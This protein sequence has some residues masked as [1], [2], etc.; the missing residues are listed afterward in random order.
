[1][2][3]DSPLQRLYI[4]TLAGFGLT[5][6][7]MLMMMGFSFITRFNTAIAYVL[8]AVFI[9]VTLMGLVW[10]G[11][12]LSLDIKKRAVK[13]QILS[14]NVKLIE[15][16]TAS[17]A[18]NTTENDNNWV[19]EQG[20][21]LILSSGK[22]FKWTE[23]SELIYGYSNGN[24]IRTLKD[25]M[26]DAGYDISQRPPKILQHPQEQDTDLRRAF[27][28]RYAGQGWGENGH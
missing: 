21:N 20:Q 4:I 1:M 22:R 3:E 16:A 8:W 19:I 26:H 5:I 25:I 23:F 18:E 7:I 24:T 6:F 9:I 14:Q 2:T 12:F 13:V 27:E 11:L 15:V 10:F 17:T 28:I